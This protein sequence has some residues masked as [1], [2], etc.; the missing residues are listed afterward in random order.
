MSNHSDGHNSKCENCFGMSSGGIIVNKEGVWDGDINMRMRSSISFVITS[1]FLHIPRTQ[2]TLS[3]HH[4]FVYSVV[5]G[6]NNNENNQHTM[7]LRNLSF[8]YVVRS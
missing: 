1:F 3:L 5:G 2:A 8:L 6:H 7:K 4:S